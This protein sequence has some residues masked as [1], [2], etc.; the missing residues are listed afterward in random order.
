MFNWH[1]V[2]PSSGSGGFSS[3]RKYKF[4][5]WY[6]CSNISNHNLFSAG[7][8]FWC[9]N[10]SHSF[11]IFFNKFPF[12]YHK[13][14]LDVILQLWVGPRSRAA[15]EKNFFDSHLAPFYR[16][17]QVLTSSFTYSSSFVMFKFISVS[18]F[19]LSPFVWKN[20]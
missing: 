7:F 19:L 16:I 10:I 14:V 9:R 20:I 4:I 18:Y 8:S 12:F 5:I 2:D 15:A 3:W 1:L 11:I 17:E 6:S 13:W